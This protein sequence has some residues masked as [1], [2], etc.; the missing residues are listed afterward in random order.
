MLRW[1]AKDEEACVLV[2]RCGIVVKEYTR[3]GFFRAVPHLSERTV[4]DTSDTCTA[5][6][7]L[8]PV[9]TFNFNEMLTAD[10]SHYLYWVNF[11][12]VSFDASSFGRVIHQDKW[13]VGS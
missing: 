4:T 3:S 1:H 7:Y 11:L 2:F 8:A 9:R 5:E 12:N 10:S 13:Q 6:P